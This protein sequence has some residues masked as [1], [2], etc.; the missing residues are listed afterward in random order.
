MKRIGALFLA[1]ALC[2]SL[3]A[4]SSAGKYD[5]L[6]QML[7]DGNYSG[8][9]DYIEELEGSNS[10]DLLIGGDLV[11]DGDAADNNDQNADPET[12]T[13]LQAMS[14]DWICTEAT[15]DYP[16]AVTFRAD[17]TCSIDSTEMTWKQ[18]GTSYFRADSVLALTIREGETD[19]YTMDVIQADSGELAFKLYCL[20]QQSSGFGTVSL[21]GPNYIAKNAYDMVDLT[22]D[23]WQEY[24]E[25]TEETTSE[26]NAFGD[27]SYLATTYRLTLKQEYYDR[28]SKYA[29]ATGAAEIS[30]THHISYVTV[31]KENKA[32]T[33]GALMHT[34]TGDSNVTDMVKNDKYCGFSYSDCMVHNLDDP[35]ETFCYH[36]VDTS[37]ERIRGTLH[38]LKNP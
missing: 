1:G 20:Q 11:I 36:P 21:S 25:W 12:E 28:L 34:G 4:C 3:A 2:L 22:T 19:C 30:Y 38:L 16:Q 35:N 31:D 7:E 29:K 15:E 37:L 27:L 10:G 23:N 17:G 8:A 5:D 14:G 32:Y 24:F 33:I 6:I 13:L 26:T 18:G 9:I